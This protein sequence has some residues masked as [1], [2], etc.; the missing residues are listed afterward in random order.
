MRIELAVADDAPAILELQKVCYQSEESLHDDYFIPP[1]RQ[2]LENLQAEF[3]NKIILKA[4][5]SGRII[6]SV[7]SY[8][9]E[10][11][12]YIERLIIHPNSQKKGIGKKLLGSVE[13]IF[14]SARR[15]QL[16]TESKSIKNIALYN[17]MGYRSLREEPLS[18]RVTLLY[19]E[20]VIY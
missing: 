20:K 16:I 4:V 1:L 11:V 12:C 13:S 2:T 8:A 14:L 17:S 9:K 18:D 6:G 5:E 10:D 15:F 3:D 19:M 7:H